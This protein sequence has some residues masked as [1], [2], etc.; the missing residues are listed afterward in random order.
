MTV[1]TLAVCLPSSLF[2]PFRSRITCFSSQCIT[3]NRL[4]E[5]ILLQPTH[6]PDGSLLLF[7]YRSGEQTD[8]NTRDFRFEWKLNMENV[9]GFRHGYLLPKWTERI[10]LFMTFFQQYISETLNVGSFF[11]GEK[12]SNPNWTL[13]SENQY[14]FLIWN[15][16]YNW[17]D[18]FTLYRK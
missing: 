13:C 2:F 16:L 14:Y 7:V 3:F 11:P 17:R 18:C 4:F 15:I 6:A 12:A 1:E 5:F 10:P 8:S 9:H